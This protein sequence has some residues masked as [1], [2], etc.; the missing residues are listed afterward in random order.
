MAKPA[1]ATK[2]PSG[3]LDRALLVLA[4]F[5]ERHPRLHL[6]ELAA[7]SGLDKATLLRILAT[8]VAHGY[9][10]RQADGRYAPGPAPLRLAALYGAT[11]DLIA[12]L[13]PILQAVMERTGESA[14]FYERDGDD[15]LCL[16]RAN[17]PRALRHQVE[18]GERL[19]LSAGGAA[20]HVLLAGTGSP[21]PLAE[22]LQHQ[23]WLSTAGERDPGLA[24][25]ALPVRDADG[26]FLG[27]LVV[28]GP[29]SRQSEQG[30][31]EARAIAAALLR[32]QGFQTAG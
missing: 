32:E 29:I 13:T 12:R 18:T 24:S 19:P 8:Y 30:S 3:V 20:A 17:A 31:A 5:S 26:A 22:T 23:G 21:T 9:L 15:R 11:H 4:C 7:L 25:I 2:P 6:R 14:A 1:P 10:R 16:C 28:S 27:A